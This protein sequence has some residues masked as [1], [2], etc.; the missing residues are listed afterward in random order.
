[1]AEKAAII[2]HRACVYPNILLLKVLGAKLRG[3]AHADEH[4]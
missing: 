4:F 3:M 2:S 1:M